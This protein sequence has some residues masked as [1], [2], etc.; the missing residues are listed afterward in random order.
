[1]TTVDQRVVVGLIPPELISK[2]SQWRVLTDDLLK[3]VGIDDAQALYMTTCALTGEL[4]ALPPEI[5]EDVKGSTP[6]LSEAL[7]ES[8]PSVMEA[9]KCVL[10]SKPMDLDGIMDALESRGW[11]PYATNPR[12]FIV[13]MLTRNQTVFEARD[14]LY[15]IRGSC[16]PASSVSLPRQETSQNLVQRM[17]KLLQDSPDP[18]RTESV[19]S[20]LCIDIQL[21]RDTLKELRLKGLAEATSKNR[22]LL[23]KCT[24]NQV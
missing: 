23:W 21:A 7:E 22:K 9:L 5:V 2:L 15:Y 6:S 20:A 12:A 10:T 24:L 18:R 8:S 4:N 3:I 11:T 13:R 16:S 1:M 14:R 19:A 17:L